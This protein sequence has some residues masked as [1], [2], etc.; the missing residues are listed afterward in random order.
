MNYK[1]KN[2]QCVELKALEQRRTISNSTKYIKK[3]C[4]L[5]EKDVPLEQV[6]AVQC[7]TISQASSQIGMESLSISYNGST[8]WVLNV[9]MR[10]ILPSWDAR[11][12]ARWLCDR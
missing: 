2:V 8:S 3:Y 9:S 1:A 11:S 12:K 6:K 4:Q 7:L 5:N 10:T